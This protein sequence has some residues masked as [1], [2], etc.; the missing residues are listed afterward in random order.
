[1][2]GPKKASMTAPL[3]AR[4]LPCN[5]CVGWRYYGSCTPLWQRRNEGAQARGWHQSLIDHL[6]AVHYHGTELPLRPSHL[7]RLRR[8]CPRAS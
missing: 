6:G 7:R 2:I 5:H 1:M 8:R 4:V 3:A